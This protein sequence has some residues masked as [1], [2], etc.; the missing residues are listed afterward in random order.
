MTPLTLTLRSTTPY[1]IDM[2]AF[3]PQRL[4][5]MA[6]HE[7]QNL[8]VHVG[9]QS[10]IAGEV[11][12]IEG[13]DVQHIRIVPE[14]GKL[15][16]I[17][18]GMS[19]GE[20]I[21][22]GDAGARAGELMQGGTLRITGSSGPYSGAGLKA[23]RLVI[24]GDG[25]DFLGAALPGEKQGMSGGDIVVR[26]NAGD[27]VGDRLRR[28]IISVHGDAGAYCGS[29]MTAGTVAVAGQCGTQAGLGMRR[30]TLLLRQAP[31][32]VPATFSDNGRQSLSFMTLLLR[33]LQALSGTFEDVGLALPVQRFLG[34]RACMGLG[35]ILVLPG[36]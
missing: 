27:R 25:G 28:G 5:G 26:G 29:R 10:C 1:R 9:R 21:V 8:P 13:E 15:D 22:D 11:F 7:I 31:A 35:E 14:S 18:A 2:R 16:F 19:C 33:E 6:L 34:D 32:S 24:D 36:G 4:H 20:M 3:V 30:G 17:G 23:G 12:R